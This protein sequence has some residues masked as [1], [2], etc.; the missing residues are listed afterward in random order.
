MP[1]E[2]GELTALRFLYVHTVPS[3]PTRVIEMWGV[4]IW[5]AERTSRFMDVEWWRVFALWV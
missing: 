4:P 2:L 1:T 3:R 5:L